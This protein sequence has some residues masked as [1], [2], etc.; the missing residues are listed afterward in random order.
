MKLRS[1][2]HTALTVTTP[3]DTVH[4]LVLAPVGEGWYEAVGVPVEVCGIL[5]SVTKFPDEYVI[6]EEDEAQGVAQADGDG[7][8]N[9]DARPIEP[10]VGTEETLEV[11]LSEGVN[12]EVIEEG[13]EEDEP[14]LPG[15]EPAPRKRGRP[16]KN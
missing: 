13:E 7:I 15:G 2:I 11:S 16:R 10:S 5:R 4:R 1:F 14:P 12:E 3:D 6:S 9:E 8:S